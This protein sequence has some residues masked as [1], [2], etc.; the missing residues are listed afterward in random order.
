[1]SQGYACYPHLRR[2]RRAC[3]YIYIYIYTYV[4]LHLGTFSK[5]QIS[6]IY[7]SNR[8]ALPRVARAHF[9]IH[10]VDHIC[11]YILISWWT[12][13][14][15]SSLTSPNF[16]ANI[17]PLRNKRTCMILCQL[18]GQSPYMHTNMNMMWITASAVYMLYARARSAADRIVCTF[19][20]VYVRARAWHVRATY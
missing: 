11:A 19:L 9:L 10:L 18:A 14:V 1:M 16:T 17:L 12:F 3:I 13:T 6:F 2:A 7:Q 5:G 8:A 4:G 15:C 20:R